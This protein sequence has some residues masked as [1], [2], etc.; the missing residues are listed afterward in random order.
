MNRGITEVVK[1][2]KETSLK[3][4]ERQQPID[5]NRVVS[6]GSTLL[7]LIVSGKR[8]H[9]GGIP[10]GILVEISGPPG[11]GK[12]AILAEIA[13]CIQAKKG[14]VIFDDIEARLDKEYTRI[15]GLDITTKGKYYRSMTVKEMWNRIWDWETEPG[16]MNLYA[17]DGVASLSS[18]MELS[19]KGDKMGQ[20]RA[21]EFHEGLRKTCKLISDN[22]KLVVLTNQTRESTD[23]YGHIKLE[24]TGGLAIPFYASLRLRVKNAKEIKKE[25]AL[26]SGVKVI[27]TIGIES[28]IDVIKSQID[29]PYRECPLSIIFGYGIDTIRDEL[30][31]YKDMM[32]LTQYLAVDKEFRSLDKAIEHIEENKLQEALREQTIKLWEE[33]EAKFTSNRP[34]KIRG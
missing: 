26:E 8:R 29:D 16:S 19:E 9:G 6:T 23:I 5:Y 22:T 17:A 31:Y 2:V 18:D 11:T 20:R 28:T 14:E 3:P 24:T 33:I 10:M 21:K 7:D 4:I 32:K 30:Q 13:A 15:Y 25:L 1:D 34:S 27:K 12:T